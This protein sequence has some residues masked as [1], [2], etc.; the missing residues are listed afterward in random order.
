VTNAVVNNL[1]EGQTYYFAVTSYDIFG[2][3]SL[4]SPEIVFAVPSNVVTFTANP[5]TI[6]PKGQIMVSCTGPVGKSAVLLT[7]T[8]MVTWDAIATNVFTTTNLF[9]KV[10]D[11]PSTTKIRFFRVRLQ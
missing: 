1:Q 10:A 4:P 7:S 3:E 5:I 11:S 6:Q 8:N 9:M 2:F